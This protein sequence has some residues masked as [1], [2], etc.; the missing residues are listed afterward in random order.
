[1]C[2]IM[3]KAALHIRLRVRITCT[4][5][6]ARCKESLK[7]LL[8]L[9]V[10]ACEIGNLLCVL[11]LLQC[12]PLTLTL[13][14]SIALRLPLC[15]L[16]LKLLLLRLQLLDLRLHISLALLCLESLPHTE[17]NGALV[18]SLV[19]SDRHTHFVTNTQQQKT[20]LSAVDSHLTDELV[21]ALSIKLLTHGADTGLTRLTLLKLLIKPFLQ[22][23]DIETSCRGA[24]HILNPELS[25]FGPLARGKNGV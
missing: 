10:S 12:A 22:V 14:N 21:K 16:T 24:R 7:L 19:S 15:Q 23:D 13:L 18:Q 11:L 9:L 1:M 2:D 4:L 20:P 6:L 25:I 3:S 17:S 8:E 5:L